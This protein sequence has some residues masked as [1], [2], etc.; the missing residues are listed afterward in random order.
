MFQK[1]QE[2]PKLDFTRNK[3]L[4]KVFSQYSATFAL[5]LDTEDFI[6][7]KHLKRFRKYV[8]K[9]MRRQL[10]KI[11]SLYR[12][13][14]LWLKAMKKQSEKSEVPQEEAFCGLLKKNKRCI[15]AKNSIEEIQQLVKK[16][17]VVYA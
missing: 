8:W 11:P 1:I 6:D 2:E 4:Q 17:F 5:T 14:Q 16:K 9:D 7:N 3:L 13:K 12:R 10:N 15:L